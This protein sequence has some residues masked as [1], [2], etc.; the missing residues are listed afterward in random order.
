MFDQRVADFV[1]AHPSIQLLSL[2]LP[3]IGLCPLYIWRQSH[4]LNLVL[5]GSWTATLSVGI[6]IVCSMYPSVVVLEALIM[7]AAITI[8]LTGYTFY[9]VSNGRDFDFMGPWLFAMLFGL[10]AFSILALFVQMGTGAQLVLAAIGAALFSAYIVYDTSQII[11]RYSVDEYV[12]ASVGL[13]L[14]IL[15][16]FLRLLGACA[17]ADVA[18][19]CCACLADPHCV[20]C[21]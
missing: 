20:V 13:Y 2:V 21:V 9:A 5:L 17:C 4:P 1:F 10:I 19:L 16:V 6:G 18:P 15:N 12:W 3:L 11:K 14:D 7:T 8:G